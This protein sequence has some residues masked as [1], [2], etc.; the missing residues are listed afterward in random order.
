[1]VFTSR[2]S[3]TSIYL[4]DMWDSMK[5]MKNTGRVCWSRSLHFNPLP[6]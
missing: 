1:L 2:C 4:V 6:A 3:F 5:R